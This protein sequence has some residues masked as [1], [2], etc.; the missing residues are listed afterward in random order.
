MMPA[1]LTLLSKPDQSRLQCCRWSFVFEYLRRSR[2]NT[3]GLV[4]MVQCFYRQQQHRTDKIFW[5][6]G[7]GT[8]PKRCFHVV[9]STTFVKETKN[10]MLHSTHFI[11]KICAQG[12]I[13]DTGRPNTNSE[14][15]IWVAAFRPKAQN[16][17]VQTNPVHK[18]I[19]T[20]L[21]QNIK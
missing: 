14:P 9:F 6:Q 12:G 5:I 2:T 3:R 17:K 15:W 8:S 1:S 19:Y 11:W 21:H 20:I 13:D 18:F 16:A 7:V 4:M 10:N